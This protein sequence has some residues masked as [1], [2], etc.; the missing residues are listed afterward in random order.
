MTVTTGKSPARTQVAALVA[1]EALVASL[2]RVAEDYAATLRLTVALPKTDRDRA[3]QRRRGA[4]RRALRQ[5]LRTVEMLV[6]G[7]V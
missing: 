1:H 5:T 4:Y 7:V 3:R 6:E 2:A